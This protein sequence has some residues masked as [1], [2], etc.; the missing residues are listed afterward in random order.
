MTISSKLNYQF[1]LSLGNARANVMTGDLPEDFLRLSSA[2]NQAP[3]PAGQMVPVQ[4]VTYYQP[5]GFMQPIQPQHIGR[6]SITVQQVCKVQ[7]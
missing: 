6:L 2:V 5:T 4:P 7:F 1:F 3:P